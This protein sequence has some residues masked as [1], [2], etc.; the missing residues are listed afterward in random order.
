MKKPIQVPMFLIFGLTLFLVVAFYQITLQ[1]MKQAYQLESEELK[2]KVVLLEK[3]ISDNKQKEDA[4]K[5][6]KSYENEELGIWFK[7]PNS[8]S[9]NKS[10][11][12]KRIS[13]NPTK[14]G[15]EIPFLEMKFVAE[16]SASLIND[17]LSRL[18][19]PEKYRDVIDK[20]IL[21]DGINGRMIGNSGSKN[22]ENLVYREI[23]VSI[24]KNKV[25]YIRSVSLD[26][27]IL[28]TL[29]STIKFE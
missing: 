5:D 24:S 23:F 8:F 1:R 26:D 17:S 28:N 16:D 22:I 18:A 11:F 12:Y 2:Q 27:E 19:N 14:L 21:I 7:Y 6:W 10:S 9:A 3:Q 20:N 25:L 15:L 4:I 29:L 13:L